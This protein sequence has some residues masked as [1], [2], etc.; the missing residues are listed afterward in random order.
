MKT[1]NIFIIHLIYSNIK[2]NNIIIIL[3][4]PHNNRERRNII[5]IEMLFDR[6]LYTLSHTITWHTSRI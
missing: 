6:Q 2:N 1:K 3:S 5:R 4:T